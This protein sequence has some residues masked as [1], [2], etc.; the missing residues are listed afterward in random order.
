MF[1]SPDRIGAGIDAFAPGVLSTLAARLPR[2]SSHS[3]GR[4]MMTV[5]R[6]S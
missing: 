1:T 5:L 6:R 4:D 2:R 3:V